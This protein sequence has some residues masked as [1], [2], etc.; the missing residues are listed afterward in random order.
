MCSNILPGYPKIETDTCVLLVRFKS[1]KGVSCRV[2]RRKEEKKIITE[3]NMG[4][5]K[6]TK[7]FRISNLCKEKKNENYRKIDSTFQFL[8]FC[9]LF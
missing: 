6:A 4:K 3:Q 2:V 5:P 9:T 8:I 1:N 7:F